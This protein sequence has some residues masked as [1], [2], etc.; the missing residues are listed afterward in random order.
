MTSLVQS[1]GNISGAKLSGMLGNSPSACN[2]PHIAQLILYVD[3]LLRQPQLSKHH[4]NIV[5]I[6]RDQ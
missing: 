3:L 6:P 5:L 4:K 1:L 2:I